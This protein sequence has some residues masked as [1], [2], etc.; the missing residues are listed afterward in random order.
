M[1]NKELEDIKEKTEINNTTTEIKNTLEEIGSR[2]NEAEQINVLEDKMMGL[3][4]AEE[5]W[6]LGPKGRPERS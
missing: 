4:A 3:T 6:L 1:F 2:V 5:A